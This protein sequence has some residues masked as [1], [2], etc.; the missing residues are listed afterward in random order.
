MAEPGASP[1]GAGLTT[2][3]FERHRPEETV[4][5]TTLQAHWKTFLEELEAEADTP[6]LPAF[7]VAEVEAFLRCGNPGQP[8]AGDGVG[9]PRRDRTL[10]AEPPARVGNGD[11]RAAAPMEPALRLVGQRHDQQDAAD[12]EA[13]SR[14]HGG[15]NARDPPPV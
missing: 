5:Y 3:S 7:V 12:S 4:L 10:A 6:A 2:A 11:R 1:I 9:D 15:Q 8:A 13:L 14:G